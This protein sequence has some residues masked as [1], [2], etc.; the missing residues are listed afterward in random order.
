MKKTLS[1]ILAALMLSCAAVGTVSAEE[2]EVVN[3]AEYA[4]YISCG[5]SFMT[6]SLE[7]AFDG[8]FSTWCGYDTTGDEYWIGIELEQP[9]ILSYVALAAHDTD[10]DGWTDGAWVLHGD[11][12]EGSNDGENWEY[13]L[14]LGD[15]YFEWEDFCLDYW[16]AGVSNY[17]TEEAFDGEV[18][19]WDEDATD[20]VAYKYYRVWNRD[21]LGYAYWGEV[22]FYG[23]LLEEEADYL[24]GDLDA[25][26]VVDLADAILL[27]NHSMLGDIYPIDYAGNIDFTGDEVVDLADAILLFNHS[28]LP[29][30]YPIS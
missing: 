15:P 6:G 29:D 17:W 11:M 13:I 26:G 7:D 12:I 22:E 3:L 19:E 27:F 9:S 24:V 14:Q 4:N 1:M 25:S 8:D 2:G 23:V 16:E 28:M 5:A 10:G 30:I 20:P 21:G 18:D